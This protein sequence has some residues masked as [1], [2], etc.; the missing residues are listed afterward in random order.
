[1]SADLTSAQATSPALPREDAVAPGSGSR[2]WRAMRGAALALGPIIAFFALWQL[3]VETGLASETLLSPP[4]EAIPAMIRYFT[5]G[6]IFPH[7]WASLGRGTVGFGIAVVVGVPLGLAIGW[8]RLL[9][10]ALGPI[11]EFLRQLPPLAMLPVFILFLGLGFKSQVAMV[12]WASMWPVLLNTV[13][14]AQS[15]DERLV[16]AARTLGVSGLDMYRKVALPA[17]LPTIVT[18]LRLGASYAFL[19]LISAEMI[20]ADSGLGF[21][22]LN[23]QFTF[24]IPEMYASILILACIGLIVNYGLLHFERA[25]IPWKSHTR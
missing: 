10:R 15:V 8:T 24:H 5:S 1:M 14:G 11:I 17:A 4:S 21:L 7:L 19:V 23:N 9:S 13:T 16:K 25:A 12:L 20:G 2:P 6:E 3:V 22:V 18:G